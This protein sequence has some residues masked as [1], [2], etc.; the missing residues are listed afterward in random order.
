MDN[1]RKLAIRYLNM[2]KRR[3]AIA[4]FGAVVTTVILFT[5][6]NVMCGLLEHERKSMR[7]EGDYEMVFFLQ[8]EE[9]GEQILSDHRVKS[10]YV[11]PYYQWSYSTDSDELVHANT[12][13]V[14]VTQPYRINAIFN[15]I[16]RD[17]GVEGEIN[18]WLASLYFQG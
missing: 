12:L 4:I 10:A 2:N 3:S 6:L 16:C 9:Q 8:S 7:E 18:D 17:Y 14:N 11:G 15:D 5:F 1:Y 13:Y